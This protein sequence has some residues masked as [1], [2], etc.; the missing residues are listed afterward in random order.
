MSLYLESECR[1]AEIAFL[2]GNYEK[3]AM[4]LDHLVV[5]FPDHPCVRLFRGYLYCYGLQ[6]YDIARQE[7]EI[8]LLLA[9]HDRELVDAVNPVLRYL[10][11]LLEK[12][13]CS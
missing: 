5:K 12:N 9:P 11:Q 13:G 8:A 4:I 2:N 6:Q 3:A 10:K 7:F 1:K